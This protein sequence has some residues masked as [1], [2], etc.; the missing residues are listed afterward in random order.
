M[1]NGQVQ[2]NVFDVRSVSLLSFVLL[3]YTYIY[4]Y[5]SSK[6]FNVNP[7]LFLSSSICFICISLLLLF[8]GKIFPFNSEM[9]VVDALSDTSTRKGSTVDA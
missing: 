6:N 7:I 5:T 9:D 8:L 4:A 3:R 1:K 2:K